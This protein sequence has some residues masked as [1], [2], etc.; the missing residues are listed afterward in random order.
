MVKWGFNGV[1]LAHEEEGGGGIGVNGEKHGYHTAQVEKHRCIHAPIFT[2]PGDIYICSM[3]SSGT[4]ETM[5][6]W[7]SFQPVINWNHIRCA[8]KMIWNI[9]SIP[10]NNENWITHMLTGL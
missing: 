7:F 8:Y 10:K 6:K 1:Y 5:R 9:T 4:W 3:L 2:F